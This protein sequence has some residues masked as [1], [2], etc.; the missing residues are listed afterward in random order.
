MTSSGPRSPNDGGVPMTTCCTTTDV[1]AR[2]GQAGTTASSEDSSPGGDE[3]PDIPQLVGDANRLFAVD[4][5]LATPTRR[6]F[7]PVCRACPSNSQQHGS[8]YPQPIIT[9]VDDDDD[10]PSL[11]R[12]SPAHLVGRNSMRHEVEEE[13]QQ[14]QEDT[15]L[16]LRAT[17]NSCP[18]MMDVN[19]LHE[20]NEDDLHLESTD[21]GLAVA[22]DFLMSVPLISIHESGMLRSP[23][24]LLPS[25]PLSRDTS[26]MSVDSNTHLPTLDR[27]ELD[28]ALGFL[29]SIDSAHP[30][31]AVM[32]TVAESRKTVKGKTK[33]ACQTIPLSILTDYAVLEK[34][35]IRKG[36]LGAKIMVNDQR[37]MFYCFSILPHAK[38]HQKGDGKPPNVSVLKPKKYRLFKLL[39][40]AKNKKHSSDKKQ[41]SP[42][43][44]FA[45]FL[46]QKETTHIPLVLDHLRAINTRKITMLSLESYTVSII[47]FMRPKRLKEELNDYFAKK[48][49]WL[50]KSLTLSKLRNLK[51]DLLNISNQGKFPDLDIST[52]AYAWVY[53]ER[54]VLQK[55]VHKGNRKLMA[56]V[57]LVL[58]FKFNQ[59]FRDGKQ[60]RKFATCIR[61]MDRKDRLNISDI[62]EAEFKVFA[63]LRFELHLEPQEVLPQLEGFLSMK[64]TTLKDY[65]DDYLMSMP[66]CAECLS[67]PIFSATSSLQPL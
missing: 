52:I 57:C 48:H 19:D 44:S 16:D 59:S 24:L 29:T 25:R 61:E 23:M 51:R 35:Y 10:L 46:T 3:P 1:C 8:M 30:W 42:G 55:L 66:V 28:L 47:P 45:T 15:M 67:S 50:H 56:G 49:P 11:L 58:A 33:L 39:R 53:F 13:V 41:K 40:R 14:I 20:E 9:D 34:S 7:L 12:M 38:K 27:N 26:S 5:N 31:S 32:D 4:G 54:L 63:L 22:K 2:C 43:S 64:E 65:Y 60:F 6:E 62:R 17:Q 36:L 21:F 37:S 18:A